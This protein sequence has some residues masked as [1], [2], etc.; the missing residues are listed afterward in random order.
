MRVPKNIKNV[1][2]LSKL[3][4]GRSTVGVRLKYKYKNNVGYID[5]KLPLSQI[6]KILNQIRF[7]YRESNIIIIKEEP[8]NGVPNDGSITFPCDGNVKRLDSV[9]ALSD[10]LIILKYQDSLHEDLQPMTLSKLSYNGAIV[11]TRITAPCSSEKCRYK[12]WDIGLK[13]KDVAFL[14]H[15]ITDTSFLSFVI[16]DE[17]IEGH[18]KNG[19]IEFPEDRFAIEVKSKEELIQKV[20]SLKSYYTTVHYFLEKVYREYTL[21][22]QWGYKPDL[23]FENILKN[24]NLYFE[25]PR[26]HQEK[27]N[28]EVKFSCRYFGDYSAW[29]SNLDNNGEPTDV[30]YLLPKWKKKL[31]KFVQV[32][33][34]MYHVNAEYTIEDKCWICIF[35]GY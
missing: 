22:K 8:I 12:V 7:D 16:S 4:Y 10:F 28:G 35:I 26:V 24:L 11:G 17:V 27:P 3:M 2:E 23:I 13:I 21:H 33:S 18:M 30:Y 25:S 34:N 5:T 9:D 6:R 19:V 32:I 20:K 1:L 14:I 31:E 29:E 15:S